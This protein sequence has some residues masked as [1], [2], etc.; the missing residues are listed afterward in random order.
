MNRNQ[1]IQQLEHATF[2]LCI[3]GGGAS[4]A[5]SALDA[6]LRGL[7]VALIDQN[8]FAAETSDRK[9]VV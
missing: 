8:D 5:G 4:G 1:N 3:I 2:D 7:R 6:T 9:S